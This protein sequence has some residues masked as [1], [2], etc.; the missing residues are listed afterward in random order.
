[1]VT[2]ESDVVQVVELFHKLAAEMGIREL[3]RIGAMIETPAKEFKFL[4][5]FLP[6]RPWTK[7]LPSKVT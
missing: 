7:D 3:P 1:M 2:T 4:T 6:R 5:A